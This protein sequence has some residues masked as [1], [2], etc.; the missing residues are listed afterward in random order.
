MACSLRMGRRGREP[1][2]LRPRIPGTSGPTTTYMSRGCD[3]RLGRLP[4]AIRPEDTKRGAQDA[5]SLR[6]HPRVRPTSE[7]T[8]GWAATLFERLSIA[9]ADLV[10]T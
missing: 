10:R 1:R 9:A 8:A 7:D 2:A 5:K 3:R 6:R 4:R